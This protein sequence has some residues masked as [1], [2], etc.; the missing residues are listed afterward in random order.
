MNEVTG[1]S[2]SVNKQSGISVAEGQALSRCFRSGILVYDLLPTEERLA[3]LLCL[4][5]F[6]RGHHA[7]R[8][9]LDAW[10]RRLGFRDARGLR[11]D[12]AERILKTLVELGIVDVNQA[13]GSFEL[14]PD[15][16]GWSRLRGLRSDWQPDLSEGGELPLREERLLSEAISEN[17]REKA[18]EGALAPERDWGAYCAQLKSAVLRGTVEEEFRDILDSSSSASAKSAD[19]L[20]RRNPPNASAKSDATETC[21]KAPKSAASEKS[22]AMRRNPPNA[23]AKSDAAK[24]CEKAPKNA[25]SDLADA[26]PSRTR[27]QASK[28]LSLALVQKAKAIGAKACAREVSAKSADD[29]AAALDWVRGIDALGH[30]ARGGWVRDR[31]EALCQSEPRYVLGKLRGTLEDRERRVAAGKL[32]AVAD[33]LAWLAAKARAEGR[34]G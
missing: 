21:E 1:S 10:S 14:R 6:D 33:P 12:K 19:D 13:Q 8:V 29:A 27:A 22:D 20:V 23:S 11:P 15:A 2:E 18:L 7:G 34:M 26:K 32:P 4:H 9:D 24:I 3:H 16:A 30:L 25:A 5:T 31:W 17:S 28:A